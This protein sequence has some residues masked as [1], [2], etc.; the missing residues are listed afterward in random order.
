MKIAPLDRTKKAVR[1]GEQLIAKLDPVQLPR[2][3]GPCRNVNL[4][5]LTIF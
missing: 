3:Q 2:L 1:H 5:P 4:L